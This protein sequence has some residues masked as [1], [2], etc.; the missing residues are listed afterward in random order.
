MFSS[1]DRLIRDR[2]ASPF[3]GTLI[4]SWSICNWKIL[5]VTFILDS[6]VINPSNKLSYILTY[7][8]NYLDIYVYPI[9]T[10]LFL[11]LV[12]PFAENK[13]YI[14]YLKYRRKRR[15]AKE[16]DEAKNRLTIE[17]SNDLKKE[18]ADLLV[19]HR[20]EIEKKD[21]IID[22]K[23]KII[24]FNDN[25]KARLKILYAGYG[26]F[27]DKVIDV[28]EIVINSKNAAGINFRVNNS[29][30]LEDD[31]NPGVPKDFFMIFEVGGTIKTVF[32]RE[33]DTFDLNQK[34][35]KRMRP[36]LNSQSL[37]E[38]ETFFIKSRIEDSPNLLLN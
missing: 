14:Q 32:G 33:Q 1:I 9:I 34:D 27:P 29:L 20:R 7:H 35:Q 19:Q 21:L 18:S 2:A 23:S 24:E 31:P 26:T 13:I 12:F 5:Y 3:F 28:T 36:K 6:D 11:V 15:E 4:L 17:E 10:T 38:T 25:E 8:W 22:R 30:T 37:M 16:N